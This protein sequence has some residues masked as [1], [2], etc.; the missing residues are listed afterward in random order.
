MERGRSDRSG[1]MD[2]GDGQETAG[3][4]L[5]YAQG[6]QT[7][8]G[9]IPRSRSTG[10][11][12]NGEHGPP[13]I[14]TVCSPFESPIGSNQERAVDSQKTRSNSIQFDVDWTGRDV[15]KTLLT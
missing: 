14:D 6:D 2:R 8:F 10:P 15:T 9:N 12:R 4:S 13:S 3:H 1:S 11:A 5:G 7:E